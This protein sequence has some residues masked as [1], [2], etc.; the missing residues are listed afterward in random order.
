MGVLRAVKMRIIKSL[1]HKEFVKR[2]FKECKYT[3][4][5]VRMME[6]M[7]NYS[8]SLTENWLKDTLY[9]EWFFFIRKCVYV[10]VYMYYLSH[11]T[12]ARNAAASKSSGSRQKWMPMQHR[13]LWTDSLSSSKNCTNHLETSQP[14]WGFSQ[15]NEGHVLQFKSLT[16]PPFPISFD[17]H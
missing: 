4:L 10:R 11:S 17:S 12:S 16:V 6:I 1:K 9:L 13:E 7:S 8:F 5:I 14:H 15:E 3:M 2:N